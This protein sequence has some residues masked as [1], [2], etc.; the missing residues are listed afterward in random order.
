MIWLRTP[1]ITFGTTYERALCAE[2]LG[3]TSIDLLDVTPEIVSAGN[4][5]LFIPVKDKKAVDRAWLDSGGLK[6]LK[7]SPLDGILVFV[8][9]PTTEGAYSRMFAPEHGIPEDPATGSATGP[10]AAFMMRRNCIE[11]RWHTT[12][13]RTGY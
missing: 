11:R 12:C 9:T 1:P 5:T 6:T 10:L 7:K 13:E 2:A 3:L 8:F 4:P